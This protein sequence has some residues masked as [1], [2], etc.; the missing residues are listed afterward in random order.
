MPLLESIGLATLAVRA[1]REVCERDPI[2]AEV[3]GSRADAGFVKGWTLGWQA[4]K[5]IRACWHKLD[6]PENQVLQRAVAL[7]HWKSACHATV[8]YARTQGMDVEV[9]LDALG[10]PDWLARRFVKTAPGVLAAADQESL[11]AI[12]LAARSQVKDLLAGTPLPAPAAV[13]A[14]ILDR[15]EDLFARDPDGPHPAVEAA[16]STLDPDGQGLTEEFRDFFETHWFD[17]LAANFQELVQT[18]PGLAAELHS[19]WLAEI[20]IEL[21]NGRLLDREEWNRAFSGVLVAVRES[22]DRIT[23]AVQAGT[24][25]VLRAIE[26]KVTPTPPVAGKPD[27]TPWPA[28]DYFCG[29]EELLEDL[30]RALQEE[31]KASLW[32]EGGFGKTQT[33]LRYVDLNRASYSA[34]LWADASTVAGFQAGYALFAEAAGIAVRGD[35]EASLGNVQRWLENNDGWLIVL[36]NVDL[37]DGDLVLRELRSRLPREMRGH[38]LATTRH[39]SL[40][41]LRRFR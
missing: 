2:A 36:D 14:A 16:Y 7:A 40:A 9:G 28:T 32:A 17:L 8:F 31:G 4:F 24:Q 5:K 18:Q 21:G 41:D 11:R 25:A 26:E 38:L 22:E 29:R 13:D 3:V 6:L 10:A 33:V 20:R 37:G 12:Y 15:L 27:T 1:V 39:P 34:I 23:V 35:Q 30:K 19:R